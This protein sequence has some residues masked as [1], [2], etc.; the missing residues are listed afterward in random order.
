MSDRTGGLADVTA[1]KVCRLSQSVTSAKHLKPIVKAF[2]DECRPELGARILDIGCGSGET[3][4]ALR[5]LGFEA[6]G[7]EVA[8]KMPK[9]ENTARIEALKADGALTLFSDN[10]FTYPHA[11]TFFDYA[12]C[13]QVVEHIEHL[14]IFS[15]EASRVL[16][17]GGNLVC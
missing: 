2:L 17:P 6:H 16:R 15:N 11:D 3:V 13:D 9:A 4:L 10:D 14:D 8:F 1:E 12:I 5:D 7:I